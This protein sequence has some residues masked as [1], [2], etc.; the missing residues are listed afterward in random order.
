MTACRTATLP[1]WMTLM[2]VE[3]PP[4]SRKT[5]SLTRSCIRAPATPAAGPDRTVSSGRRR[6]S[7]RDMTPPSQRITI[8]GAR[9][10]AFTTD[11]S[12]RSAVASILGRIAALTTA[13]RVRLFSP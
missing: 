4:V 6:I 9:T 3:V 13:V 12:T 8:S 1:R 10:P 2:S 11:S 7:S 5:P